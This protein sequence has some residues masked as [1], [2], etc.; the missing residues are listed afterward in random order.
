MNDPLHMFNE[1]ERTILEKDGWSVCETVAYK[2]Y[3]RIT[4]LGGEYVVDAL[5]T[6]GPDDN[7]YWEFD[8]EWLTLKQAM[9]R[10][11]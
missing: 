3:H 5:M 8:S 4:K 6:A 7:D 9:K 10:E 1:S 11:A 2:N